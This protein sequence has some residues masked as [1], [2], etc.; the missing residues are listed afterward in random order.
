MPT[1]FSADQSCV[2]NHRTKWAALSVVSGSLVVAACS[3]DPGVTVVTDRPP[4][5][6][7]AGSAVEIGTSPDASTV[8]AP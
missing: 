2:S 1:E 7:I 5:T 4:A 3:T 8:L 6:T